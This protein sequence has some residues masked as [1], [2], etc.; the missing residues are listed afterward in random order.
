MRHSGG[1]MGCSI[2]H[3]CVGRPSLSCD[4]VACA[5]SVCLL[6]VGR[7]LRLPRGCHRI[8]SHVGCICRNKVYLFKPA[9]QP[10]CLRPSLLT[11]LAATL[12]AVNSKREAL[13]VGRTG[14]Q[15]S[16]SLTNTLGWRSG[17]VKL[18]VNASSLTLP[19]SLDPSN[20]LLSMR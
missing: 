7:F 10:G 17:Y 13:P 8:P 6:G 20:G 19:P 16:V 2:P 1:W 5:G 12:L 4:D 18:V 14:A 15:P 11:H 9:Q 3:K